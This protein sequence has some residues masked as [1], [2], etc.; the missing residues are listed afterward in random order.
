MKNKYLLAATLF[1]FSVL[2]YLFP[3]SSS[4]CGFTKMDDGSFAHIS[5]YNELLRILV[6]LCGWILVL[7][8]FIFFIVSLFFKDVTKKHFIV[9]GIVFIF[10][11]ILRL[12][13]YYYIIYLYNQQI[14]F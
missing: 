1:V 13:L 14:N 10:S 5:C 4:G 2:E 8:F 7:F 6:D 3:R 12:G 11:I 9:L